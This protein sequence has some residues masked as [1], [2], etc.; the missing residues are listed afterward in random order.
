MTAHAL[1][2]CWRGRLVAYVLPTYNIRNRFVQSRIDKLLTRVP[3]YRNL[4]AGKVIGFDDRTRG[5][6]KGKPNAGNRSLKKFGNGSI[7]F[8]GAGTDNDFVEFTADVMIVDEYDRCKLANIA[9]AADRLRESPYPQYFH[10]S[11][12]TLPNQ[13]IARLYDQSDRRKWHHKCG[14]CGEHQPI[15]WF[16]N[17]VRR[18]DDGTWQLRDKKGSPADG[19]IRPICRRCRKPFDR[20]S[21]GALWVAENPFEPVRGYHM[22]RLDVLSDSLAELFKEWVK[23][24]GS[25]E[26]VRAFYTSVLGVPYQFEGTRLSIGAL[27][28]VADGPGMDWTGGDQYKDHVVTAG[29]DVGSFLHMQISI[30][31]RDA[32]GHP[33][34]ETRFVG[35]LRSFEEVAE[36]LRRFHVNLA[37]IDAYPEIHKAQ[38]LRDEF[39]NSGECAVWLCRFHPTPRVG[40]NRYGM[41]PKHHGQ[42]VQVDRTAVFDVSFADIVNGRRIFPADVMAVP[43]WPEQMCAP[44]RVVSMEKAKIHWHEGT[45]PDHFRLADVYDRVASDLLDAGGSFSVL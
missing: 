35:A 44:V 33:I 38:E 21:D 15:D 11:N 12:P 13:G 8:L 1:W 36:A 19:T 18:A 28:A 20:T 40:P 42:V 25:P 3:V 5:G 34:R 29:I 45:Q 10:I 32:E 37:V 41:R 4:A 14:R 2:N 7:L 23:A 43:A 39:T 24:Q 22:S 9:L 26:L 27:E 31:A 17:I 30:V 6:K 16:E